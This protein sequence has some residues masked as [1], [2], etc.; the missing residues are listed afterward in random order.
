V[1]E[2]Y[3]HINK[4]LWEAYQRGEVSPPA[5]ARER[6]RQLLEQLGQGR[7][8]AARLAMLYMDG[9]ARR[10]DLRPGSRGLLQRLSRRF[11]LATVT[12]GVDR[13]QRSRLRIARI[14]AYFDSIITS[15][16][17]GF[18]KPDPRIVHSA[19][20]ALGVSPREAVLVGDDPQSD[21]AA[22]LAAGV[23]FFWVDDGKPRRPGVRTPRNRIR[24]WPELLAALNGDASGR[25]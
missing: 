19:L 7:R 11:L 20:E 14:E 9:L 10:G 13:V 3:R 12:N 18:A 1:L 5:L 6:F 2:T 23:R 4:R 16:R 21:G 25:L 24:R 15:E 17:C 22:A 8:H